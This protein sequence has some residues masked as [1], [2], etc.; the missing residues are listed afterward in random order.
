MG[1]GLPIE[2]SETHN[3]GWKTPIHGEGYSSPVIWKSHIWLTTASFDERKLSAV[4][5]D[6]NSGQILH[7]I[8]VFVVK[9]S[10][11]Q[12]KRPNSHASPTPIIEQGRVYVHFG[13]YGTACLNTE[14]GQKIWQRRDLNCFHEVRPGSSPIINDNLLYLIYD[15]VDKQFIVALD[16]YSGETIWLKNDRSWKSSKSGMTAKSFATPTIIKHLRKK[17]TNC[18]VSRLHNRL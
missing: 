5:I 12:S 16:K 8:E 14:T 6:L 2:F 13:T 1:T 17:A 7:D 4:C 15:G 10:E 3:L 9:E 18:S 11:L